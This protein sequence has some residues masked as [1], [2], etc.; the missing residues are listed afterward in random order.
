MGCE[1]SNTRHQTL[2]IKLQDNGKNDFDMCSSTRE[3]D[4]EE[5]GGQGDIFEPDNDDE[6]ETEGP[7][8]FAQGEVPTE[9]EFQQ[10]RNY[11]VCRAIAEL[12]HC[13]QI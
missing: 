6:V 7:S 12:E 3:V 9:Q 10:V 13:N 11:L 1:V 4:E 5:G 2:N 8:M